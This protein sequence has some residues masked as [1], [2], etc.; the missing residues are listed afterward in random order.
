MVRFSHLLNYIASIAII[1]IPLIPDRAISSVPISISQIQTDS[2]DWQTLL[3]KAEDYENRE[4]YQ[5]AEI[6]YRQ[7]LSA[8][9]PDSMNDW[10]YYVI[11]INL[12]ENLQAQG[13][14]PDA[15]A[16]FEK[17]LDAPFEDRY[18]RDRGRYAIDK[19]A[20]IQE[21]AKDR[22]TKGLKA[23]KNDPTN[24]WGYEDL[25]IGLALENRLAQGLTFLED[26]LGSPLTPENALELGKAAVSSTVYSNFQHLILRSSFPVT[27]Q[28]I[29]LYRQLVMRYPRDR[30]IRWGFLD[31]LDVYGDP[32]ESIAAYREAIAQLPSENLY[33]A[34][35]R[36]LESA[37]KLT[38]AIDVYKQ[39][40]DLS[41]TEPRVYV[42]L[43][44]LL[45]QKQ[46]QDLALQVYLKGIETFPE[47][48][49]RDRRC[50]VVK[51]TNYDRLVKLLDSQNRLHEVITI[52]EQF[53]S[54]PNPEIYQNLAI[55]L[56]YEKHQDIA[57]V[58]YRRLREV[59]P[60]SELLGGGGC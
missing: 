33:W 54:H 23:I 1:L 13:K 36:K 51:T 57:A 9:Q 8:P 7:I 38:E 20:E 12:G 14:F 39:L 26:N 6:L 48:Y 45:E 32:E 53:N 29:A 41:L 47:D 42:A 15:I 11:H 30:N 18:F 21:T 5:E 59:Y 19:I 35:A 10:M 37:G 22:I 56:E 55:A 28:A 46:Q 40:I 43:G 49:P 24:P 31:V 34:L 2:A 58:V 16:I 50:H 3:E 52:L 25:A 17:L 60:D 44:S 27:Q 4:R